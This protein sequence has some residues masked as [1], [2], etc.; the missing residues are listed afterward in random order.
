MV[1]M[2]PARTWL[3]LT[4]MLDVVRKR[5]QVRRGCKCVRSLQVEIIQPFPAG[6]LVTQLRRDRRLLGRMFSD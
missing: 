1:K 4:G 6:A 5:R 2:S 3:S